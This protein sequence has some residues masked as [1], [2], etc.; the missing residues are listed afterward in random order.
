MTVKIIIEEYKKWENLTKSKQQKIRKDKIMKTLINR[1]T[2]SNN[3]NKGWKVKGKRCLLS[4]SR[5]EEEKK[6][7]QD[8]NEK[9]RKP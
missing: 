4:L 7:I 3:I 2:W 6:I 9:L 5:E 1:W 8:N